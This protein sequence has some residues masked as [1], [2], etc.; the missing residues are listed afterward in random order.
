MAA[1]RRPWFTVSSCYR[2]MFASESEHVDVLLDRVCV[3]FCSEHC[4]HDILSP[5]LSQCYDMRHRPHSFVLPQGNSNLYK[6]FFY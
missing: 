4:L 1:G 5:V 3:D 2:Y 6:K